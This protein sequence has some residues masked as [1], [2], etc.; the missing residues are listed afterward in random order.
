MSPAPDDYL[1][2]GGGAIDPEVAR[3]EDLLGGLAHHGAPPP[4][5]RRRTTSGAVIIGVGG[6]LVA[7]AAAIAIWVATRPGAGPCGGDAGFRFAAIAG[8]ARCGDRAVAQGRLPIGGWLETSSDGA[9]ELVI[10]DLGE[11]RIGA[12]SRVGLIASG[13]SEH[14]L[15]L[16]R[17][18]LHAVV[19]APPR[20]FVVETP[21]ATAIDLGCEY[22]L[23]VGADGVGTLAV[24]RGTV[25]LAGPDRIAVVPAGTTA[26]TRTGSGPGTPARRDAP[27]AL[28]AALAR[29]DDAR[30]PVAAEAALDDALAEVA[31]PDAISLWNL[32]GEVTPASRG[33]IFDYLEAMAPPPRGVTRAAIVAGDPS[34]RAAWRTDLEHRIWQLP[35]S[36]FR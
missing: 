28:V 33:R 14:R 23:A 4:L 18:S 25:E 26:R 6:G 9:A 10:A 32:L 20:L 13:P 8:E 16:Q 36:L 7:I 34:A 22:D 11:V 24:R 35:G 30:D 3:L 31:S 12:G 5:P 15:A 19:T 17:G 21:G 1:W 29:F 27:A 2:D